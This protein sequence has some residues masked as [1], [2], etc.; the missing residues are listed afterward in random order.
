MAGWFKKC[1]T[2][3]SDTPALS[4][5]G[6]ILF[7]AYSTFLWTLIWFFPAAQHGW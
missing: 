2:P 4:E 5:G 3:D 7:L 1:W 6:F